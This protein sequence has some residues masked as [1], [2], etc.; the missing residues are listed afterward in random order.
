MSGVNE[1]TSEELENLIK[2]DDDIIIIDVREAEEVM[3]GMIAGAKHIPLKNIQLMMNAFEDDKNYIVVCRSGVR[4]FDATVY[5]NTYGY[6]A[7]NLIGGM[8]DWKGE[9]II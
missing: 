6:K 9:I 5:L 4:S 7:T 1:I 2:E 8:L 3:F